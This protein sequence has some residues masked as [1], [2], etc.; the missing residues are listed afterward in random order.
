[1]ARSG[2]HEPPAEHSFPASGLDFRVV[3]ERAPLSIQVFSPDGAVLYANPAWEQVWGADRKYLVGYNILEDSQ[4]K[5]RG[6]ADQ[7]ARVFAGDTI[8]IPS[9]LYDPAASGIPGRPRWVEIWVYAVRDDAGRILE[10]VLIHQDVTDRSRVETERSKLLGRAERARRNAESAQRLSSFLAEAGAVL[11]SSLDYQATLASVAHLAV[12]R[13]ADWCTVDVVD[14]DGS[15]RR[16]AIAHA[17]PAMV[18]L[19]W[20]LDRKYPPRPDDV[21]P[22]VLRSG[23]AELA[24]E[25]KDEML[26][27]AAVDSEQLATIR[28]LGMRSHIVV[29][30]KA[31]GRTLGVITFA[32]AESGRRYGTRDLQMAE[33][34]ASRAA[35]AIDN[36]RLYDTARR[37]RAAAEA[38]LRAQAESEE[39]FRSLSTCSPVGK[40][41][42]DIGGRCTWTN[43]RYHAICGFTAEEA[44]GNGWMNFIHPDDRREVVDA[45]AFI[46]RSGREFSREFRFQRTDGSIRWVHLRSAPMLSSKGE[47]M[48]HVGTV[49]DITDSKLAEQELRRYNEDLQRL[50]YVA[51]HDLKEPLRMVA[52]YTQ[53]L[54]KRYRGRLDAD[55]DEI[56]GFVI[57]GV[58]RMRLLIDDLLTYSRLINTR[59]EAT[60]PA[61]CE[62]VLD[63]ALLNLQ[64]AIQEGGA[65][66]THGPLPVLAIDPVQIG[67]L[68]QNLIGNAIKYRSK[69]PLRIHVSAERQGDDWLFRVEDNGIG[70]DPAYKERIFGVFKRLHG[71][72][73]PGT[74]IG[75]AICKTIVEG[76]GGRIWVESELGKGAAFYFTLPV[77][78][79]QQESEPAGARVE[80]R[81]R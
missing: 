40:F 44:L 9:F 58:N 15:P 43:P 66:I 72:E 70:I 42:T 4:L 59:G 33:E 25:I 29:P 63:W 5:E 16:L 31:L 18:Q 24:S 3:F 37:D 60:R 62:A 71:K 13:I 50:A 47:L 28:K 55:A 56:I 65:E 7:I 76:H 34:M 78:E 48:G 75:L 6:V 80:Y 49:E 77:M 61:N 32:T 41:M 81:D 68:F 67:Q 12:P 51:S 2:N 64:V 21:V 10:I 53:M 1:M 39:R 45:W 19:A 22:R 54:A 46:T 57:D 27:A 69:R 79:R 23:R 14:E 26:V 11:G 36:A 74:G 17:D 8:S 20:E 30:M 73:Y 35:L 38:A 52:S